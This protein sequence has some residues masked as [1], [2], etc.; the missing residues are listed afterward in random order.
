MESVI[1]VRIFRANL[2][3]LGTSWTQLVPL[4][5]GELFEQTTFPGNKIDLRSLQ[6]VLILSVEDCT[7]CLNTWWFDWQLIAKF[8]STRPDYTWP[9]ILFYIQSAYF[10]VWVWVGVLTRAGRRE[11]GRLGTHSVELQQQRG[12]TSLAIRAPSPHHHQP[13][14]SPLSLP[15]S[16]LVK[17]SPTH[18]QYLSHQILPPYK[19][20]SLPRCLAIQDTTGKSSVASFSATPISSRECS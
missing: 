10:K 14:S 1:V 12:G 20:W 4:G 15:S 11:C 9:C 5:V 8:L 7:S 16:A 13:A 2:V 17:V 18:R 6:L 3:K 19:R